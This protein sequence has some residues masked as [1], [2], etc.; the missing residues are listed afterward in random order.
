VNAIGQLSVEKRPRKFISASAIGIYKNSINHTEE[1]KNYDPGFVGSLVSDWEKCLEK[2]PDEM[3]FTIFRTGLVLG[4]NSK[5]IKNQMLPFKLGMGA[6]LGNGKQ[7]FPFI[8]EEDVVS[9]FIM[10]VEDEKFTGL[11]NLVAP[12]KISN[13]DFSKTFA[14]I[15]GRPLFL[16]IP[17]FILRVFL[18]E[19]SVLLIKS[20]VIE[21]SALK[22]VGF[23]YKFPTLESALKQ[24]FDK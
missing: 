13:A 22:N 11:F 23:D 24:I 2:L 15:L 12:E 5:L 7:G 16:R 21:P 8:H 1:S 10:A 20:P 18:G 9:A 17:E 19:V 6:I 3:K 14:K 4:P